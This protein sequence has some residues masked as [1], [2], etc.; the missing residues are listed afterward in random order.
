MTPSHY[1]RRKLKSLLK[2]KNYAL[3]HWSPKDAAINILKEGYIY[4]KGTLFGLYYSNL[5]MLGHIKSSNA[6]SEAKN[7]FTDYVFL[8]NTNWI[9]EGSKS[10]Y[11]EVCF[12]IK[13]ENLLPFR[14]FFVFPFNTGR[15]LANSNE[16]EQVSDLTVLVDA[17]KCQH[18]CYEIL[19]RRKIKICNKY[20]KEILCDSSTIQVI[21]NELKNAAIYDIPVTSHVDKNLDMADSD[22][23]SIEIIDPLD[24]DR[25]CIVYNRDDFIQ[26]DNMLYVKTKF[27][28]CTLQIEISKNGELIE[29]YTGKKLGHIVQVS[30]LVR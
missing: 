20:I 7:G 11:G 24:S 23:D 30:I 14:E 6:L 27:S 22:F 18:P 13:P 12:V 5:Q 29:A 8:G 26:R 25:K 28:N 3:Y 2:N 15:Y 4:S 21:S 19:I 10:Y 1:T 16:T 17:L 9:A